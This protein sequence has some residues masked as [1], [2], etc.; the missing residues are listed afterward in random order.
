MDQSTFLSLEL[1]NLYGNIESIK[2]YVYDI[3]TE[4]TNLTDIFTFQRSSYLLK[5][6][7][8]HE[9]IESAIF[10]NENHISNRTI[11]K[12]YFDKLVLQMEWFNENDSLIRKEIFSY[13]NKIPISR[14]DFYENKVNEFVK[15]IKNKNDTIITKSKFHENIYVKGL[16]IKVIYFNQDWFTQY[17]YLDDQINEIKT[18]KNNKMVNHQLFNKN[19]DLVY[20]E[21]EL[22]EVNEGFEKYLVITENEFEGLN[23]K[24]TTQKVITETNTTLLKQEYF[25]DENNKIEKVLET[26][27]L[28]QTYPLLKYTYNEFGNIK[29]YENS[30]LNES[31]V[32][33]Y[34]KHDGKKNW[35]ERKTILNN[36]PFQLEIRKI[37]YW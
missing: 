34:N 2:E 29:T 12:S 5:F 7:S 15:L 32:Y 19:Q 16:L 30:K 28:N 24:L 9:I 35:V 31:Y 13:Q 23:L 21:V 3:S 1:N 22:S 25:Y 20:S 10:L 18:F 14:V 26:N 27:E 37:N 36:K 4:N 11:Y 33:E 6:N 8:N 17:N